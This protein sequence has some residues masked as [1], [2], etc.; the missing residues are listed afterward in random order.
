MKKRYI[1]FGYQIQNGE[2]CI[3]QQ[4]GAAVEYIFDAYSNG[5]SLQQIATHMSSCGP[6]YRSSDNRWNKNIIARLL[7]CDIYC[8]TATY[9]AIITKELYFQVQQL[10]NEKSVS[11]SS[12]LQSF[13][14]DM[15]CC[16]GERLYWYPKTH[17][18]YCRHCGMWSNPIRPEELSQ[19][20]REKLFW[21]CR[22][23]ERICSPQGASNIHS[24]ESS[25][26]S[27]E[28]NTL[29]ASPEPDAESIVRKILH[30]AEL[31]FT[32]CSA[33]DADPAT[34]QIKRA[35]NELEP[36]DT[37]PLKLYA[38][39]ISNVILYRDTHIEIKLRNGQI[40]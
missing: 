6:P 35:C 7:S 38:E 8:G 27:H 21:I 37:F 19:Q 32:C 17:Q 2:F 33:G 28:I 34:L 20:L 3:V 14:D 9:P 10:R 16:C 15:Q 1:L 39:I 11:Y 31:Q 25:R 23:N 29:L 4:E 40:L 26:L 36:T 24:I 5:D 22:H 12:V 18:W 13:R 30:R